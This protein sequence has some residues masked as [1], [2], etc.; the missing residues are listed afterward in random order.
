M[1][2]DPAAG[3]AGF[4]VAAYYHARLAN[5]SAS[6]TE[7]MEL[8]GKRFAH[9]LATASSSGNGTGSGTA[10]SSATTWTRGW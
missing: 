3:T 5:S 7:E 10:P 8:D 6:S 9:G 4:L 2:Y 1:A